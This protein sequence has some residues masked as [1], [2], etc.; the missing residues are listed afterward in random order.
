M[1]DAG[2]VGPGEITGRVTGLVHRSGGREE[3]DPD[4]LL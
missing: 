3:P 2:V 1:V 4:W